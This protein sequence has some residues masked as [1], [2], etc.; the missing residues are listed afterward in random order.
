M[1]APGGLSQLVDFADAI[2]SGRTVQE[3]NKATEPPMTALGQKVATSVAL[4]Q[5]DLYT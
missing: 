4:I 1:V 3:L 5:K 2:V